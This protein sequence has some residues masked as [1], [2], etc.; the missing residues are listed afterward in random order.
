MLWERFSFL[1]R[2]VLGKVASIV[3]R[4]GKVWY[5]LVKYLMIISA[6]YLIVIFRY[7]MFSHI[8]VEQQNYMKYSADLS[9]GKYIYIESSIMEYENT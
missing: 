2:V 9:I 8:F 7:I 6:I 5:D 3:S 1:V 4:N